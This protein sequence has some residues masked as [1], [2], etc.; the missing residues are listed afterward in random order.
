MGEP[1]GG[2]YADAY[3]AGTAARAPGTQPD[4]CNECGYSVAE[5]MARVCDTIWAPR[6]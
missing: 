1:D 6:R 5:C 2:S 3:C 4:G